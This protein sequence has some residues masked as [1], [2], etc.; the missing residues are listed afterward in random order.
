MQQA[1]ETPHST[2]ACFVLPKETL[3]FS[4]PPHPHFLCLIQKGHFAELP[5]PLMASEPLSSGEAASSGGTAP[6]LCGLDFL[7]I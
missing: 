4:A 3:Y 1:S 2:I 7:P 5:L 6:R